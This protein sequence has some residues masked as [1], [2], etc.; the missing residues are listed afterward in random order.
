MA[1]PDQSVSYA[2]QPWAC[3]K[4][5]VTGL[6]WEVK[7]D[8]D[9]LHDKDWTYTWYE[10]DSSKNGGDA[11]TQNAGSC[12]STS[13]CDTHSYVPAVN[14]AGWCGA[15]D[16]RMP[17]VDELSGIARL[18]RYQYPATDAPAIDTD[19]FPNTTST[20]AQYGYYAVFW[21]SSPV[22]YFS[23]NA[24]YVYFDNGDNDWGNKNY[25]RQVRLVRSGQ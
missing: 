15:K 21:S 1:L 22:A 3:V 10:P 23:S 2:T 12:G 4:D 16:W 17:T 11:G 25:A 20:T 6:I 5:N 24:W 9:G 14:A 13:P 8:D 19:F 7:T 18:D